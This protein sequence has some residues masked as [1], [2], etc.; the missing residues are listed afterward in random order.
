MDILIKNMKIPKKCEKCVCCGSFS[1]M[2][3]CN[4]TGEE[5]PMRGK[6][7]SCP[8]IA[9][10]EH[11]RLIDADAFIENHKD[12]FR[13]NWGVYGQIIGTVQTPLAPVKKALDEAPTILEANNGHTD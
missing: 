5:I 13:E 11:G 1:G 9:L 2:P 12:G 10:P 4:F 7:E 6:L 8:L 3:V